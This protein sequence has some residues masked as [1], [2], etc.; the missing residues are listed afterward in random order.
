MNDNLRYIDWS[1]G[2]A[3]PK[4]LTGDDLERMWASGKLF[5]RKFDPAR[6]PEVIAKLDRKI[7]DHHYK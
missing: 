5:A 1:K 6:F 2:Q 4:V 7:Q 3:S